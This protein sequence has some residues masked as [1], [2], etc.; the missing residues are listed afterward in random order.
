MRVIFFILRHNGVHHHIGRRR[1]LFITDL[2]RLLTRNSYYIAHQQSCP[3]L[4]CRASAIF[5][6]K[7]IDGHRCLQDKILAGRKLG[8][9]EGQSVVGVGNFTPPAF[10]SNGLAEIGD[11]LRRQFFTGDSDIIDANL[12]RQNIRGKIAVRGL[13]EGDSAPLRAF[14][15]LQR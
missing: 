14:V 8:I 2:Q 4:C 1:E 7:L 5:R 13:P 12:F 15:G 3:F 6:A 11:V 9:K 10:N